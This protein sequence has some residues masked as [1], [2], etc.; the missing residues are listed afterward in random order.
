MLDA[1]W[2]REHGSEVD[3][4]RWQI[5][6]AVLPQAGTISEEVGSTPAIMRIFL[7]KSTEASLGWDRNIGFWKS[8]QRKGEL[9][10][11]G[12]RDTVKY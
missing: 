2:S 6:R 1:W 5:D 12:G 8:Y 7:V 10:W 4:L 3:I 9:S 11:F